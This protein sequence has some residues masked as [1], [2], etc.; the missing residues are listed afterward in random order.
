MLKTIHDYKVT[1]DHLVLIMFPKSARRRAHKLGVSLPMRSTLS[2]GPS[3][4][5]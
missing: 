4:A 2:V 1:H 3:E 5:G